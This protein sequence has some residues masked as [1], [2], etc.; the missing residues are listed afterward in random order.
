MKKQRGELRFAVIGSPVEHSRSPAMHRAAFAALGMPHTYE[1]LETPEADL[2]RRLQELRDGTFAGLNVTIPH[3]SRVLDLVDELSPSV[4]AMGA[5]NTLVRTPDKLVVAH[6]T[7]APALR[8]ELEALGDTAGLGPPRTGAMEQATFRNRSVLVLGTGGAAR[9]AVVAVASLGA[10][11]IIVR[12]RSS[13]HAASLHELVPTTTLEV[14]PLAAPDREREDLAAI[15]Q[16]TSCG[17]QGG[18]AGEPVA[19]AVAWASVPADAIAYDVVYIPRNTPFLERARQRG[20]V[21]DDGLGM[22]A[23]QGALA[24]QL[25]LGVV[26]PLDVM[27]AALLDQTA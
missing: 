7:D 12:A 27:R 3:K 19:D 23:R 20:L 21:C 5:A 1:K 8:Q 9:A 24:F 6:N 18:P 22:L 14:Q 11:R 17:M 4:R 16:A 15:V 13:E 10:A 25:W 26:P 2:P